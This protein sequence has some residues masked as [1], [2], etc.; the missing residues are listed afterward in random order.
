[1]K[2]DMIEPVCEQFNRWHQAG[3][4]RKTIQMD[5]AGEN[6]GLE[7]QLNSAAWKLDVDMEYIARDTHMAELS[8][9][10]IA[11]KGSTL[12]ALAS[13]PQDIRYRLFREAMT[14]ATLWD[15]L[16]VVNVDGKDGTGYEHFAGKHLRFG[17][18]LRTWG[19]ARTVKLKIKATPKNRNW[20]EQ[21]MFLGYAI[22]HT[23]DAYRM[24]NPKT[25]GFM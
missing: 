9:T 16:M 17:S 19:E 4:P 5:N 22:D 24:W 15:N 3:H 1:M 7:Q 18:H 23:G 25:G 10:K 20:G 11:S 13:V 14:T 12:M 8:P 21:C 2:K 6:K